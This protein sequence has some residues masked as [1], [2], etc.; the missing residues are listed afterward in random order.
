MN[1]PLFWL[2]TKKEKD[3]ILFH[4]EIN[5]TSGHEVTVSVVFLYEIFT[6]CCFFNLTDAVKIHPVLKWVGA[7]LTVT[8]ARRCS[9][10][11]SVLPAFSAVNAIYPLS[12]QRQQFPAPSAYRLSVRVF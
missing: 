2:Y 5:V 3:M 9:L 11:I 8:L 10:F 4:K 12:Y 7:L 6:Y 1:E